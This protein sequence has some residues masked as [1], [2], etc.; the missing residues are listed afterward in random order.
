MSFVV[1]PKHNLHSGYFHPVFR[2]WQNANVGIAAHNLMYPVFIV[3]DDEAVTEIKSMPGVSRYGIDKL[4]EA[5]KPLVDLGL[6][7]V[8]LFGVPSKLPKDE[9]ATHADSSLN[10]VVRAV[11]KLREWFPNLVI[12]CDVCLCAYTSHGHCGILYKD[13]SIDNE[14]SIKRIAE[15]AAAYALAGAQVVAPSDMMDGRVGA[16]KAALRAA[17]LSHRT[18]V[19]SYSAKFASSFYG[20]FRDA[21][22]S[23]PAFGDRRCYQLPPGSAGLAT[24]AIE[25]DIQEGADMLIVKPGIAY[26]DIVKEAKAKFPEYPL[27]VYQVSGEYAMLHH[28]ANAGCF[29]LKPVLQEILTCMRRA[30]GDVIITY[31]TPLILEWLKK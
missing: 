22:C 15:Q 14:A 8:L 3:D 24:R 20:P 21:A 27:F 25:R 13:G 6:V 10:P 18:A 16:I 28:G 9:K 30:G 12:A 1:D 5:L 31:F 19:L 4:K 11:P 7:S 2:N 29:D 23:A 17:N 26:L